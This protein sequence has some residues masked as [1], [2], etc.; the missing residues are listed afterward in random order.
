MTAKFGSTVSGG[1][2]EFL[3]PVGCG[4]NPFIASIRISSFLRKQ[5]TTS[6]S[7]FTQDNYGLHK[8]NP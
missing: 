7:A 4:C 5:T 2:T 1:F 8:H 3:S 6:F